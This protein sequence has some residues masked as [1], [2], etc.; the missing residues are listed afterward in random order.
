LKIHAIALSPDGSL[1]AGAAEVDEKNG[2]LLIW[3]TK[4]NYAVKEVKNISS[5]LTAVDFNPNGSQIVVGDNKGIIKMYDVRA[6][7]VVRVLAGH[8][9]VI[10]QIRFNHAGTFM[11][12]ASKDQTVLL[13]NIQKLKEQ[14]IVLDD[15]SD[16]VWSATFTPDDEQ[17]LASVHSSTE[18]V[19]GK[20][21]TIHAWPTKIETMSNI[22]CGLMG[23][24]MTD[25]EWEIFVAD[26]I[27][28]EITC[29]SLPS[30]YKNVD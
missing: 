16:W 1:I 5:T 23:R 27:S 22:L 26:D 8:K 20:E 19:S 2:T 4:Q 3:D 30:N 12:T 14:P 9:S 29:P 10:E 25:E 28:K 11:A 17:L 18:T 21:H 24:N 13:L 6:S 15:H 7:M